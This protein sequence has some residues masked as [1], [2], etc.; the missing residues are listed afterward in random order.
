MKKAIA[1]ARKGTGAT[2]PNPRVGALVVRDGRLVAR[3]YHACV[4]GAHAEVQALERAGTLAKGADLIVTLEPCSHHGRTPPCVTRILEAGVR[5]VVV[6]AC[7]PNPRERGRGAELLRGAGVEV[8]TGVEED[9][10]LRLNEAYAKFMLLGRP[11]V[12][13]KMASSL[14]GRL[15]TRTGDS[16][17]LSSA[18]CLR[19][20]HRL[21]RDAN[22]VM[23]G[24][25][26][27]RMDRPALT[28]R[29]VA[30]SFQPMR[31]VLA[32]SLRVFPGEPLFQ[33]AVAG[34]PTTVFYHDAEDRK[35]EDLLR[36]Q[37]VRLCRVGRTDAGLDL[38]EVLA[39]LGHMDVS[40][41]LVEGGGRLA[42]E[43]LRHHLVDRWIVAYAPVVL[44]S[45]ALPVA[46]MVG[47]DDMT[48]VRRYRYEWSRRVGSDLVASVRLG[49]DFAEEARKAMGAG[50]R[51]AP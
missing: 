5:R 12:T 41:L 1:E 39:H 50:C 43:L 2:G 30:S 4:G 51:T 26:T 14:D 18:A 44:G 21:R 22:A 6:G 25:N 36:R 19:F 8:L 13:L 33:P 45:S 48:A 49:P 35:V 46:D 40:S 38:E 16:Q 9:S 7:D 3:G 34:A 31:V 17:W 10:C 24:G 42:G 23:V 28:V 27:A 47:P 11:F 15:A 29:H 37:G 32:A 20:V